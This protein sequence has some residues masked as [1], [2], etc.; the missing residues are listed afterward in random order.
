MAAPFA[1]VGAEGCRRP[2][3]KIVPYAK[4]PEDVIP[5]VPSDYATVVQSRGEAIGLVLESHE[6]R[7]REVEGNEQPP[8]SRG[9]A[10]A[11][12][13]ALVLELYDPERS[14]GLRK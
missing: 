11:F 9:G 7:P 10:D 13:Q 2:I 3:E 5:G 14:T 8:A 4:M 12:A 6:G 1:L